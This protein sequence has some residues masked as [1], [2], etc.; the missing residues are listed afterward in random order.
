MPLKPKPSFRIICRVTDHVDGASADLKFGRRVTCL[1]RNIQQI[2]CVKE[3]IL[4]GRIRLHCNFHHFKWIDEDALSY[5]GT[6]TGQRKCLTENY[7][8]NFLINIRINYEA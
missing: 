2:N 3:Y 4:L 8:Q 1:L 6:E 5:A 7:E